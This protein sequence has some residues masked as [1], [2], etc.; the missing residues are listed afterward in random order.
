[1]SPLRASTQWRARSLCR[2]FDL[3]VDGVSDGYGGLFD[4]CWLGGYSFDV[5]NLNIGLEFDDVSLT[6]NTGYLDASL[7]LYVNINDEVVLLP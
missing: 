1:M 5:G 6:P 7:R 4:Q 2:P 3:P